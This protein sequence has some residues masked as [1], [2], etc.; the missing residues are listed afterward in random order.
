MCFFGG[1]SSEPAVITKPDYTSFNQTFD[2]QKSAIENQINNENITL[3]NTLTGALNDRQ[4][5]LA[6][7]SMASQARAMATQQAAM[8]L[9]QVAGPPPR[10]K[11]AKPPKVGAE[12]R[13]VKTKKGKGSL[14]I[15]KTSNKR[16]QGSGL[17]I[18]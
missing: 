3:Q 15:G 18:T 14:R 5:A 2:L 12:D 6:E 16:S 17:N 11:H 9:S 8:Q 13:G 7:L 1:G 10:E 4:D